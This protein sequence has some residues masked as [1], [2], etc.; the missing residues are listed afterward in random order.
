MSGLSPRHLLDVW[1]A[2]VA[3][4]PRKTA[5]IYEDR[6]Y[7]YRE[8]DELTDLLAA[9]LHR[10]WGVSKGETVAIAM[11][12]CIEF[13]LSYWATIKLGAIVV[14]INTRLRDAEMRYVV[15][16]SAARVLL[17]HSAVWGAVA[18]AAQRAGNIEHI[19]VAGERVGEGLMPFSA[20][21]E[22]ELPLAPRPELAPE[23]I[24]VVAYTS[25]TTGQPK[26]AIMTHDNLLFNLRIT[27]L[28]FSARHEDR[29][30]LVVPVFHATAVYSLLPSSAYLGATLVIAPRPNVREIVELIEKHRATT[31]IGV[32]TIFHFLTQLRDLERRDLSSLRLIAYAGAVMPERTIRA[33]R[34]KFPWVALHNFFGL[35][36]TI[37]QT[38][39]LPSEDALERADSVGKLLP[40]VGMM[41]ADEQGNPL[42]PGEVG[43]LCFRQENVISGY[44]RQPG[45]LEQS[46]RN[47]WFHTG[48]L[49][50]VD[51]DGYLYLKGRKK[52]LII[53]AGEN[54]YAPEVENVI[55]THDKVLEVAVVGVEA[56]GPRAYLGELVKAV[57]VPVQ[58]AKLTEAE[59][60][61]HCAERLASYKVPQIVEFRSS[62]PRNPS[63]K[64]LKRELV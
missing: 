54:V 46:L 57:V 64:V 21:L 62:L 37:S 6:Y 63:G 45:L 13:V 43:E 5:A 26:G 16:N 34:E 39:V 58:G 30:L 8:L 56:T 61:R 33:L 55:L 29:H 35:T 22:H 19:A 52:E 3:K 1:E 42:P 15:E 44:W 4:F 47:G 49:A 24:G 36:E 7:S 50:M 48:D 40:E 18:D 41:I 32:P 53:V 10:K 17:S 11:P 25:G 60:K 51:E 9:F 23:D 31:F 38:H 20:L 27:C 12:N 2:V 28:C 14:P 59:I